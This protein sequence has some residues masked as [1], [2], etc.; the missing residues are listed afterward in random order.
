M[1]EWIIRL[2]LLAFGF[3]IVIV[4][5]IALEFGLSKF[6]PNPRTFSQG[7]HEPDEYIGWK[8]KPNKEAYYVKRRLV[9]Y[10]KINSHGFRDKERTYEKGKD[11]FRIVVL[12]DSFSEALQVPLEKTFPYILE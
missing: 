11:V 8:G 12:G 3:I 7:L 10:V 5:M 2:A 4:S 9:Q 1:K 6:A